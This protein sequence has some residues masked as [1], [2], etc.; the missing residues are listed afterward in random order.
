MPSDPG[1]KFDNN[2]AR[3]RL[4]PWRGAAEVMKILEYGAKKYTENGWQT[5]PD[6]RKRYLDAAMRHLVAAMNGESRDEE[7][8]L[9]HLAHAACNLLFLLD[10]FMEDTRHNVPANATE[11]IPPRLVETWRSP[12]T[13]HSWILN[14][15]DK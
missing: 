11:S 13:P 2:K 5:V 15:P 3:W 7:S 1:V 8:G 12:P 4:F 6:G 14:Y 9:P 10:R